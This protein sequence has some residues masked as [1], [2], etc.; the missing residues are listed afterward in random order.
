MKTDLVGV[1]VSSTGGDGW[2]QCGPFP[3]SNTSE[4]KAHHT[5]PNNPN[6]VFRACAKEKGEEPKCTRWWW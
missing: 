2:I 1:D 3:A 5:D 6:L 4:S